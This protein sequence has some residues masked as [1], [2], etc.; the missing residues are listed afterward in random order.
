[1]KKLLAVL[2]AVLGLAGMVADAALVLDVNPNQDGDWLFHLTGSHNGSGISFYDDLS[3]NSTWNNQ[4]GG[5]LASYTTDG[6]ETFGVYPVN[7]DIIDAYD[8]GDGV[9]IGDTNFKGF[10]VGQYGFNLKLD[11]SFGTSMSDFTST[12][13]DETVLLKPSDKGSFTAVWNEGAYTDGDFTMN[14]SYEIIPE[15][16]AMGLI[17]SS[18]SA[19]LLFRGLRR[20]KMAGET[21]FP[22]RKERRC[23]VFCSDSEW[24]S[25]NTS[26]YENEDHLSDSVVSTVSDEISALWA[27]L[28]E[29]A[30]KADNAFWDYMVVRHERRIARRLA[31]RTAAKKK[32]VNGFDAFLALILK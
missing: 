28:R 4:Q 11:S 8:V 23:D 20:R 26:E 29:I 21:L 19:L 12:T 17:G 5:S 30:G 27:R 9:V 3:N 7:S 13:F 16:A 6:I 10:Y 15:P 25:R 32:L 1:M 2:L 18:C 14:V 31:F 24:I 22:V